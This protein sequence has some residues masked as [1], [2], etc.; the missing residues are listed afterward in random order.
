MFTDF[1]EENDL[2]VAG[3]VFPHRRIYKKTCISPD[4]QTENQIDRFAISRR[5]RRTL[6]DVRSYRGAN[7][8]SDHT[9][10]MGKLKAMIQSIKKSRSQRNPRL[11]ISKLMTVQQKEFSLSL[12]N[13]FQALADLEDGSLEKKWERVKS[14]FTTTAK[15]ELGSKK[16]EFKSWLSEATIEKIEER[17]SRT[18][19]QRRCHTRTRAQKQQTQQEY[20][21]KNSEVKKSVRIDKRERVDKLAEE[22]KI[23]A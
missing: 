9:L 7:V 17:S 22:P 5:W 3:T 16:R 13:T 23:A 19:K 11:D 4:A 6:Q 18:I 14:S 12:T 21:Q 20:S 1:C 15:D 10:V 8:G 2:I